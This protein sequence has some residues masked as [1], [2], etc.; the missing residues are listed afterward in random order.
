VNG[1]HVA[2]SAGGNEGRLAISLLYHIDAAAANFFRFLNINPS[3]ISRRFFRAR[4]LQSLR[5]PW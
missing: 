3:Q 5:M 1:E 2:L 4:R